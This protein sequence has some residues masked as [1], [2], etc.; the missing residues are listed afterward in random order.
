MYKFFTAAL[1]L[2][3]GAQAIELD[4][5]VDV[6]VDVE[7]DA[8]L[9]AELEVDLEGAPAFTKTGFP[10][11]KC[12]KKPKVNPLNEKCN[13]K[14]FKA[15]DKDSSG[16]V[17]LKE[18]FKPVICEGKEG[19]EVNTQRSINY[20]IGVADVAAPMPERSNTCIGSPHHTKLFN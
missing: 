20:A 10:I 16:S 17:S 4:A 3:L 14:M 11:P 1:V 2:A 15:L 9:L 18:A 13:N 5:E 6:D 8:E 7:T 12:G 19:K